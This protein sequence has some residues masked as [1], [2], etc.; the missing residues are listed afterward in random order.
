MEAMALKSLDWRRRLKTMAHIL[1]SGT[2]TL[3]DE[4]ARLSA[5]IEA[6]SGTASF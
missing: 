4:L 3:R 5:R 6:Q 1:S 2:P